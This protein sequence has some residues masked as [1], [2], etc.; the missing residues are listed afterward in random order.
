MTK[1]ALSMAGVTVACVVTRADPARRAASAADHL[2]ARGIGVVQR[3]FLDAQAGT[4]QPVDQQ[5]HAHPGAADDRDLHEEPLS[6]H[7][8]P[9]S[10][11]RPPA[12]RVES[13]PRRT[14]ARRHAA[15]SRPA[16]SAARNPPLNA[17]P[18]PVVSTT[19]TRMR[20][21][22]HHPAVCDRHRP[23]GPLLDHAL[24]GER[25]PAHDGPREGRRSR[26]MTRLRFVDEHPVE[27]AQQGGKPA[28]VPE[29]GV[30]AEV[31][32][33]CHAPPAAAVQH[34][35]PRWQVAWSEREVQMP[36]SRQ[37]TAEGRQQAR[38]EHL[39]HA[40]EGD[41]GAV[42][43]RGQRHRHRV[44][45]VLPAQV[46]HPDRLGLQ[47]SGAGVAERADDGHL[48]TIPRRRH[49]RD[50]RATARRTDELPRAQLFA[51]PGQTGQAVEHKVLENLPRADQVDSQQGAP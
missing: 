24:A 22:A 21:R 32:G 51:G 44:R 17:S 12:A 14:P 5:G 20:R 28:A 34:L 19:P 8:R 18:A 49:G 38:L 3:E 29:L 42:R 46:G 31:P 47:P 43:A 48:R 33:R 36:G 40:V 1:R 39:V 13:E 41:E 25:S 7:L 9:G 30:P 45:L 27:G 15:R 11:S 23:A 35:D 26:V 10:P 6:A 2:E 16:R 37:L 50:Q 4:C